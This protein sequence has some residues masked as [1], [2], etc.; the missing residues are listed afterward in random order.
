MPFS[1][2]VF[3][4]LLQ[5]TDT[6]VRG[7]YTQAEA[8][9]STRSICE[10]NMLVEAEVPQLLMPVITNLLTGMMDKLQERPD[11][12]VGKLY[13]WDTTWL[14]LKDDEA[15]KA[16]LKQ[17]RFDVIRKTEIR[18][19]AKVRVCRRCGSCMEDLPV[20]L[21]RDPPWLVNVQKVCVCYN[22]WMVQ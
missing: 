2:L 4:Q 7:A 18:K 22:Y 9:V 16:Y 14:G 15:S 6:Q 12:D 19:G 13:F 5:E 8:S 20:S 17:H 11:V 10:H 1:V 3:E 21:G